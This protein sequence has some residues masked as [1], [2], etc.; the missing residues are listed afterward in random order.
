MTAAEHLLQD[1]R[2]A[3]IDSLDV[4][5]SFI[6]QAPAGSGKTELLIQRYLKLLTIVEDPE[7]V[8]A[9]TFTKRASAE[10]LLRV[11]DALRKQMHGDV[12][13]SE[14]EQ[15]TADLAAK[16]LHRS[17]TLNWQLLDNPRRLRIVTL[18]A[19]NASISRAQPLTSSAVGHRIVVGAEQQAIHHAAA[20]ATLDWLGEDGGLKAATVNV[21]R[22]VDNN[23]A[24]YTAYVAQMLGSRD[25]WLPFIGSGT[26]TT[27][28]AARLRSQLEDNLTLTVATHLQRVHKRFQT[29]P[30]DELPVLLDFAAAN[31][32]KSDPAENS[33]RCLLGIS[34]LPSADANELPR[35]RGIADLLMTQKGQFRKRVDKRQGFPATD[36]PRK[37]SMQV[38]LQDLSNDDAMA[39]D[40]FGVLS[41]PPIEYDDEQWQVLL[42]LF[43][44]LPLAVTELQHLFAEQGIADHTEVALN[45]G[46]A[47]GDVENPTDVALLLDYRVAHL[48]VDE[49]QDTSAAQYRLLETLTA[50]WQPD[51]GKTLFCVGDPMQSIYRFRNAQV[52]QFM[53]AQ[54]SGIGTVA[55]QPLLLRRNFRSGENLVEWF[56]SV[57]PAIFAADNDARRGA[58]AYSASIPVEQHKGQ[59]SCRTL[60]LFGS[61]TDAEASAGYRAI[62]A[63]LEAFPDDDMAVLVRGR[64]QLP[65]LLSN[66]RANGIPYRAIEIDRLT[67]LPEIIE[68]LALTR[69]TAHLGDRI[70]WLG[71][72]R[73]P[74]IGLAWSDLLQLVKND[75]RTT[76][77][78]AISDAETISRLS[79]PGRA[80][81]ERSRSVLSTLVEPRRSQS[82]RDTIERAWLELGGA[83]LHDSQYAIENVYRFLA[84][85]GKLEIAGTLLDVAQL[86][87]TL[88]LERVSSSNSARLQI[89]TMHRAKGL[90]FDHVLL[91]GLGRQPGKGNRRVMSWF[92]SPHRGGESRKIISPVG[93]RAEL[94]NDPIH[95]YIEM[96][97]AQKDKYEQARLLY[98]ACTR[99]RKTL[100]LMG[101]TAL[102]T[103]G[104]A[105]KSARSDSLLHLLW[106]SVEEEFTQQFAAT[107]PSIA[108]PDTA[109]GSQWVESEL[110]RFST[111][112]QVPDVGRFPTMSGKDE[113]DAVSDAKTVEFYWVGNDARLAGTL[114]HRWLQ[115]LAD[116]RV[117]DDMLASLESISTRWLRESG[118]EPQAATG[119]VERVAI[120]VR[121]MLDDEKGRWILH[122]EGHAELG[123]SGIKDGSVVSIVID[124]VRIDEQGNHWI[125]DYKTSTHEGG[126]LEGFLSVEAD[127]Y[128]PQLERYASIYSDWAQVDVKCALYFPLLKKFIE[129]SV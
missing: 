52:G 114:V 10:M 99:A 103:N 20:V 118:I 127:R 6:V 105:F 9:I 48:L 21:L 22:H 104:D 51:D 36:K 1:D 67:D 29:G 98:V 107:Q 15:V 77:F 35:W 73:S 124:R 123:L 113:V 128:K 91:F 79:E 84:V 53:F 122:G 81:L 60:A 96:A 2:Q 108:T 64:T 102:T 62:A 23:T 111:P 3:R 42:A 59:G 83:A 110:R 116:E 33:I 43:K 38:L 46:A 49:M 115:M 82:L 30:Y 41:L 28:E 47:L 12:P 65:Q 93:A 7:E 44:L 57:F 92:D 14:H 24:L 58:V 4:T 120:A 11:S 125:I 56:N 72:L 68:V 106:T 45:A 97:E 32:G 80:A 75:S 119:I 16:V 94:N 112:W 101:N 25:Q 17:E 13:A 37:E 18:D 90:Q 8:I 121:S 100:Q 126:N 76:V 74:L 87:S 109:L 5:R 70:A 31:I 19:L 50:G 69:A 34:D 85:L 66:L 26:L 39:A 95:R 129:V 40:L 117:S 89:M 78:E 63:T 88:D 54:E 71:L 55:L 86:E 27:A 61:D